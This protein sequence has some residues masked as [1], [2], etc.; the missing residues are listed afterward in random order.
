MVQLTKE[1]VNVAVKEVIRA[2]ER[3]TVPS[4]RN[5]SKATRSILWPF[6]LPSFTNLDGG[7][8]FGTAVFMVLQDPETGDINL[9]STAWASS[10]RNCWRPDLKERRAIGSWRSTGGRQEDARMRIIAAIP[11]IF[12]A[13]PPRLRQERVRCR[14]LIA[15]RAR[16]NRERSA[17]RIP[18]PAAAEIVLEGRLTRSI[19]N[20]DP[21]ASIRATQLKNW[22]N[23]FPNRR[24]M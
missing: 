13:V 7:R 19:L 1:W 15:R 16:W 14:K 20:Q 4:S 2:K 22:L 12:F 17:H 23:R 24:S 18:I 10:T 5:I 11:C 3:R 21:S 9:G 6:S 8:Y